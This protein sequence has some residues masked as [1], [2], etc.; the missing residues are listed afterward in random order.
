MPVKAFLAVNMAGTVF[1]LWL[2]RQ[3]GEAFESPI[4][5]LVDWI[6]DHRGPLLVV[7]VALVVVSLVL[8][9]KKGETEVTSLTRLE[10]EIDREAA[11]AAEAGSEPDAAGPSGGGAADAP[12]DAGGDGHQFDRRSSGP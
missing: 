6:G 4:D 8:E 3:F 1:R 7:T 11:E 2:V 12:R 9:A 5:G 10:D